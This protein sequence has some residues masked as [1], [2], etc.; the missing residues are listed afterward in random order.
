MIFVAIHKIT[1]KNVYPKIAEQK[2]K[3]KTDP[4]K[5][6]TDKMVK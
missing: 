2:K 4:L 6:R 1:T 3:K 5:T